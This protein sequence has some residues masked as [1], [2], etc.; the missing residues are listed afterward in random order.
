MAAVGI[1]LQRLPLVKLGEQVIVLGR[2]TGS[3]C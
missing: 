2:V 1:A 3:G